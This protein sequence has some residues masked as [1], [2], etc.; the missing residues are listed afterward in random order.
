MRS[1]EDINIHVMSLYRKYR[2]QSFANLVGQ[3]HIRTTL[4]NALKSGKVNHAYLFTGPRG[5]GKTS[6]ARLVA[7]AI[8]CLNLKDGEPCE[9]C[10]ICKEITDGRLIDLI[11]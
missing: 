1:R 3:D 6:T 9:E 11:E 10:D 5:T 4:L 2:P 8:N 7:K